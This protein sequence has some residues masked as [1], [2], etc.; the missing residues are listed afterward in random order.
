VKRVYFVVSAFASSSYC[1]CPFFLMAIG[2]RKQVQP[3]Y[4]ALPRQWEALGRSLV[5]DIYS[6][7][8]HARLDT[9][10]S[11]GCEHD[12]FMIFKEYSLHRCKPFKAMVDGVSHGSGIEQAHI[13]DSRF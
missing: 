5:P 9:C 10:S 11:S 7:A 12:A 1:G 4:R 3:F 13:V 2:M 6:R 8:R